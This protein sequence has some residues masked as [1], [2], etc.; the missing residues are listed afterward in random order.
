LLLAAAVSCTSDDSIG[1]FD[2]GSSSGSSS[3]G[4]PAS[5]V[6]RE[7]IDVGATVV[8][9]RQRADGRFGAC[10]VSAPGVKVSANEVC[11]GP[12]T[13]IDGPGQSWSRADRIGAD[14]V[15]LAILGPTDTIVDDRFTVVTSAALPVSVAAGVL[16]GFGS[17]IVC[18]VYKSGG[19]LHRYSTG[20]SATGP[21]GVGIST[22]RVSC[23][24]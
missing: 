1:D 9:V 12:H 6:A 16:V 21:P 5:V 3:S 8:E 13:G 18:T 17:G 19:S 10:L 4:D 7:R 23:E 11:V 15:F 22:D 2:S 20:V 24:S 14:T